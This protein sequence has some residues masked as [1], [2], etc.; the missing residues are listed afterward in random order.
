MRAQQQH[1]LTAMRAFHRRS[2]GH[3]VDLPR[4]GEVHCG[5]NEELREHDM[6]FTA[7]SVSNPPTT[8]PVRLPP[9]PFVAPDAPAPAKL[10]PL[11]APDR[12]RPC[13]PMHVE[14][15][16][17]PNDLCTGTAR[18]RLPWH[19][20]RPCLLYHACPICRLRLP[21]RLQHAYT[22]PINTRLLHACIARCPLPLPPFAPQ[23]RH[24]RA[25][26]YASPQQA[27]ASRGSE[28]CQG[29]PP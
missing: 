7:V 6:R 5:T 1:T 20:R 8:A 19:V 21:C 2:N 24:S 13:N 27:K 18:Q 17:A 28:C 12:L 10:P 3:H 26:Q 23:H 15:H 11:P 14:A 16:H 22:A 25:C 9:K 29:A 4:D